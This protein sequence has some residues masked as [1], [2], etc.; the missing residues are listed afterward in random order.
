MPLLE[1]LFHPKL[2]HTAGAIE[3]FALSGVDQSG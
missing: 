2:E 1:L 3:R